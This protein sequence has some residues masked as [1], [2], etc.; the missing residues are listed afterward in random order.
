MTFL[1]VCA[2]V[3]I[4][5][6]YSKREEYNN[7]IKEEERY[8]KILERIMKTEKGFNSE[9]FQKPRNYYD[10]FGLFLF[11]CFMLTLVF[12][13]SG[14]RIVISLIISVVLSILC[15][16]YTEIR[17]WIILSF[18][19]KKREEYRI[20]KEEKERLIRNIKKSERL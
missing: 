11:T 4:F 14:I 6:F 16:F 20:K 17:Q 9:T 1:I 12:Y 19:S 18:D 10:D 2:L 3:I 15:F 5:L 13:S 8:M 7:K